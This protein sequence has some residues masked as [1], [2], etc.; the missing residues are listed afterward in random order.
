MNDTAQLTKAAETLFNAA[1]KTL[2]DAASKTLFNAASV[3][4]DSDLDSDEVSFATVS[5]G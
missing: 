2:F 1:G 3:F 4:E 5:H